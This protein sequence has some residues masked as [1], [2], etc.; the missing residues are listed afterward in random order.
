MPVGTN[1]SST[2]G[3][4]MPDLTHVTYCGLYC[5]LC[6]NLARIPRESSALRD[7]LQREGWEYFG[8][9]CVPNFTEFWAALGKL[10]QWDKTCQGC[11]GGCGNPACEIRKCAQ[12]RKMELCSSCPEYPCQRIGDLARRYPNLISDGRRQKDIGLDK[13]IQEQEERCR[14][15][16]CYADIRYPS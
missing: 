2:K 14:A 10:S 7:T 12:E 16:F 6:A 9:Y 8:Q 15:G 3:E 13:W 1:N 11:R 5:R 4:G